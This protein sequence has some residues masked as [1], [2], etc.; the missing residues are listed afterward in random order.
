MNDKLYYFLRLTVYQYDKKKIKMDF[1]CVPVDVLK[2]NYGVPTELQSQVS[3]EKIDIS[4]M[5]F[6]KCFLEGQV[7]YDKKKPLYLGKIDGKEKE[8]KAKK[9][10]ILVISPNME[11]ENE[12]IM[13]TWLLETFRRD[14]W[15]K[16]S[17]I[18][19]LN[20]KINNK[21]Y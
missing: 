11:I 5:T 1:S 9:V 19:F 2:E 12:K 6:N 17:Y 4:K 20:K 3:E 8:G 13:K 15:Y 7:K 14:F 16:R 18:K 21:Q 10:A